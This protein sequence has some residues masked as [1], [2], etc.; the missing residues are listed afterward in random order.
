MDTNYFGLTDV[1]YA[2]AQSQL[3]GGYEKAVLNGEGLQYDL[4]VVGNTAT[5]GI[6]PLVQ[7]VTTSIANADAEGLG[8]VVGGYGTSVVIGAATAPFVVPVVRGIPGVTPLIT[9]LET[10]VY[11][12]GKAA[13]AEV[14][15]VAAAGAVESGA[16]VA[17][18]VEGG[19]VAAAAEGGAA[20]G[21]KPAVVVAEPV[22]VV[23]AV[24]VEGPVAPVAEPVPGGPKA[25]AEPTGG[26]PVEPLPEV[27]PTNV[28][29]VVIPEPEPVPVPQPEPVPVGPPQEV[30]PTQGGGGGESPGG[31]SRVPAALADLHA[32]AVAALETTIQQMNAAG[33]TPAAV[34][35]GYDVVTG[36]IVVQPSGNIPPPSGVAPQLLDLAAELGG[37]GARPATS[38]N[39]VGRCAEFHAANDLL[40]NGSELQNIRFTDAVRPRNG[41]VIPACDNCVTMFPDAVP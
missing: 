41:A 40:L 4:A 19:A 23:E 8:E 13:A 1:Y 6:A 11:G 9:S 24:P 28:K 22:V 26:P 32:Q 17:G 10:A 39:T 20:G 5:L 37:L 30:P 3:L 36:E 12:T 7:G 31:N 38:G 21:I 14:A 18:S 27:P 34:V 29:P 25:S 33:E 15:A 2:P 35:A 16:V